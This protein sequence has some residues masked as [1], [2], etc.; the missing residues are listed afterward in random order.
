MSTAPIRRMFLCVLCWGG[1]GAA[2]AQEVYVAN[3]GDGD[4]SVLDATTLTPIARI[5]VT[6]VADPELPFTGYPSAVV[7]SANHELAF[8][9]LSFGAHVAVINTTTRAV[10][11]YIEVLPVSFDALVFVNPSGRNLYITSCADPVISVVDVK[12]RTMT[13]AIRLPSG[14][15]PMAFSRNGQ[16]GYAGNGY[17]GC[18]AVNGIHRF[19]LSKNTTSAFIRTS[20]AI[21][22]IALSPL[23]TFALASGG[24]RIVVVDLAKNMEIGAAM[25]GLAPCTY[26]FG[27]GLV[28][29]DAGTRAYMIDSHGNTLSTI[30]TD[31][32]SASFLHELSRVPVF[33]ERNQY[34]WQVVVRHNRAVVVVM[35]EVS[36]AIGFDISTDIPVPLSLERVGNYAYELDVWTNPSS[37]GDCRSIGRMSSGGPKNQGDCPGFA[38]KGR[39]N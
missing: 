37:A 39:Q 31:P 12:S 4:V 24:N 7:F 34:A 17:E 27:G 6:D 1:A 36:H 14:S 35:G 10:V 8:V 15:Y 22:D 11:D 29:N 38:G 19:N 18:G 23:G 30:D 33:A 20:V 2:F 5:P 32:S 28:F 25:C 3:Y 16:T 21:S 9:A 13:G 26:V